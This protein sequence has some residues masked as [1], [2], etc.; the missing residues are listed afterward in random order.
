MF[1]EFCE[2]DV[3]EHVVTGH[4]HSYYGQTELVLGEM[5]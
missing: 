3:T 2:P 1:I 5:Y 4:S